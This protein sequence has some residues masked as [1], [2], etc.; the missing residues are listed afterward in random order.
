M[1]SN[2]QS[3]ELASTLMDLSDTI[4]EKALSISEG[5]DSKTLIDRG[6]ALQKRMR[7]KKS[8]EISE[9]VTKDDIE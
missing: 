2:Q 9:T 5:D 4:R 6:K 8:K 1:A 3:E 7:K